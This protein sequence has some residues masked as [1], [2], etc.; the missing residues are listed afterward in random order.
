MDVEDHAISART[1]AVASNAFT[2]NGQPGDLYPCS[3]NETVRFTVVPG[4][5]YLLR[6]INAA[7]STELF[8]KIANHKFTVVAVDA[9][10]TDRYDTD[11]LVIAPGQ[12][13]DALMVADQTPNY[14]YM[15]A[16]AF[17]VVAAIP[18]VNISTTAI[19]R[20]IGVRSS[21]PPVMPPQPAFNDMTL[22]HTFYSNVTGLTTSPFWEAV[23]LEVDERMFVTLGLGF[24]PCDL[25]NNGVCGTP[26][27]MQLVAYMNSVEFELPTTTSI[28]EA[29]VNNV[30]GV[31]TADFPDNPPVRFDYTNP[32]NASKA[33]VMTPVKATR[34]KQLKFNATVEVVFQ[35]TAVVKSDNHPMHLH[36]LSFHVLGMGFGNYEAERDSRR[37]N[38]VNP[39]ERNTVIVP[40]GGWAVIRFKAN[41]PG[42]WSIH[43]HVDGH[44]LW[45]MANAF[46]VENGPTPATTLPPPPS[47]LPKC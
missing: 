18:F 7:L 37:F 30:S 38:L 36:G 22:A 13:V 33:A 20:Y 44:V 23:P 6:I 26:T 1:V 2:I 41:N 35:N 10:Y 8:F 15:T 32:S 34:V 12:T 4:K 28:M 29:F 46:L 17:I 11:V 21:T 27:G 39:Q 24:S 43:C 9:S 45:G 19:V 5:T 25:P 47:D 3:S 14:Y 40:L 42:V 31:Y 16:N